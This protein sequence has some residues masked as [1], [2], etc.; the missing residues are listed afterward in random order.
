[1]PDA[2]R[3]TEKDAWVTCLAPDVC[4]TPMGSSVVP[5]PY[6]IASKLAWSERAD[7]KV[8]FGGDEAFT[9]D[10]RL[11][12][13]VGNEGGTAGGV[14]SGVNAG[15]CKPKSNKT[16]YFVAGKEVIQNDCIFEMNCS[17]PEGASNTLG[18]LLFVDS[19]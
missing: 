6:M 18:K 4:L 12:K 17:G 5:V 7:S 19:L 14:G 1:M 10:S 9:M 3:F 2:A 11:T 16:S 15:Y 13:V 8:T